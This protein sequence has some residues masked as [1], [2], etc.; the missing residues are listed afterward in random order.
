GWADEMG[1]AQ[2]ALPSLEVAVRGRGATLARL[3]NVGI[4]T[5]THGAAGLAPVEARFLEDSVDALLLRLPLHGRRAGHHHGSNV[6]M[7][8]APTHHSRRQA[9][10]FDAR[11]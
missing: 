6:G 10:V 11:V 4:H 8:A 1:A 2:L 7:D 3:Q 9:Q 5:Q